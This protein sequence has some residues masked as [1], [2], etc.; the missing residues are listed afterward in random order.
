MKRRSSGAIGFFIFLFQVSAYGWLVIERRLESR[1]YPGIYKKPSI[2]GDLSGPARTTGH[3]RLSS[4]PSVVRNNASVHV[5][6]DSSHGSI[7][8]NTGHCSS[9][10][11]TPNASEKFS[12][13]DRVEQLKEYQ[14][15]HGNTLVPKRYNPNQALANWVNRQRQHYR[16]YNSNL[17]LQQQESN[18]IPSP[19]LSNSPKLKSCSLNSEQIELLTNIGFCWDATN[20]T[21]ISDALAAT[22]SWLS[23][24]NGVVNVTA[25]ESY[26]NNTQGDGSTYINDSFIL[27]NVYSQQPILLRQQ[28]QK[29]DNWWKRVEELRE[30]Q[31]KMDN[32]ESDAVSM[33][34]KNQYANFQDL[35]SIFL[36][37]SSRSSLG[38]WISRQ[39]QE[40]QKWI[41]QDEQLDL[42]QRKSSKRFIPTS[43]HE[44][45]DATPSLDQ[46]KVDALN[47]IDPEWWKS[48]RQRTWDCRYIELV[49]YQKVHGDC[50]VPISYSNQKLARWVSNQRRKYNQKMKKGST[51]R[52]NDIPSSLPSSTISD[53]Q[54]DQLNAIGFVWNRWE[55]EFSMKG[56]EFYEQE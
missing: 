16:I 12:W 4:S 32:N 30:L 51:S 14:N 2:F 38:N 45:D 55:Y 31:S 28:Q 54:I 29:E 5:R 6:E 39:R 24:E 22:R 56:V 42:K 41:T 15:E 20:A 49:E 3:L 23:Q 35:S 43:E 19:S 50:C 17:L 1:N 34:D 7:Q 9:E 25:A 47:E 33:S 27:D 26:S 37:I 36:R 11:P 10:S 48:R 21:A 8:A 40:Y 18:N 44:P 13:M 53:E 46:R 52:T